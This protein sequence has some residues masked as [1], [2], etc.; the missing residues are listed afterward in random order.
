MVM[1]AGPCSAG[2]DSPV[3]WTGA[4][5]ATAEAQASSHRALQSD[6]CFELC[7]AQDDMGSDIAP[8]RAMTDASDAWEA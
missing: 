5:K 8:V 3:P 7:S 2:A 6:F 1:S 4:F